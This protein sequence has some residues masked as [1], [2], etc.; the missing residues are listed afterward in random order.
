MRQK[1]DNR[2]RNNVFVITA[3]V[4]VMTMT[5]IRFL[6]KRIGGRKTLQATTPATFS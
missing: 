4:V 1:S 5:I 6:V 3:M 2:Y